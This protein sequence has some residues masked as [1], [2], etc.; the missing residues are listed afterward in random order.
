[1]KIAIPTSRSKIQFY[2]NQAYV[3]YVTG[4]GAG[5]DPILVHDQNDAVQIADIC[6]GL[7]LPG[8]IDID[9]V[10]YGESNFSSYGVEPEKDDFERRLMY[11]FINQH[12]PI[13]G[14]CR[15]AQL[16]AREYLRNVPA[17]EDRLYFAQHVSDHSLAKDLNVRRDIRTHEIRADR[18][19]LYSEEHNQYQS[20][21]VNS[22]HHQCL[23]LL[24]EKP[25][26][27][28]PSYVNPIVEDLKVL[29]F[30]SYGMPK[31][32]NTLVIEAFSIEG[33]VDSDILAVQWHPEELKDYALLTNFFGEANENNVEE[34]E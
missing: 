2:I 25:K 8:G 30:T 32:E 3:E 21:F 11:A 7:I 10:F 20:M 28:K 22:M 5:Y 24:Q 16:I 17:A 14:I 26:K 34:A 4:A 12:K 23:C 33:W 9:P 31:K 18:N 1:M 27:G 19:T 15:G 29:A 13:F 6:E